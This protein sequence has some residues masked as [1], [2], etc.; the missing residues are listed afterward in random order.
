MSERYAD[1]RNLVTKVYAG[2]T[3][4]VKRFYDLRDLVFL[5]TVDSSR[6]DLP[7]L[8][9]TGAMVLE[10]AASGRYICPAH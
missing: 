1:V 10:W 3:G 5:S 9:S 8:V 7:T 4:F 6:T 2:D